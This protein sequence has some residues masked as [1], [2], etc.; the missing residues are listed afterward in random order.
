MDPVASAVLGAMGGAL[1]TLLGVLYS[2]R[3][4]RLSN[5]IKVATDAALEHFRASKSYC[6][7]Y[8]GTLQPPSSFLVYYF[9]LFE[10]AENKNL[11]IKSL[12]EINK[13]NPE[14][15]KALLNGE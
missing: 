14:F 1:L 9:E 10:L 12:L 15:T 8:G 13:R 11:T 5:R 4:H 3:Q 2:A 7:K 6:E